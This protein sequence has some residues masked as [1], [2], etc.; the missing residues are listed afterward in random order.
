VLSIPF[1]GFIKSIIIDSGVEI[2]RKDGIRDYPYGAKAWIRRLVNL[3]RRVRALAPNAEVFVTCGDYPDD[4]RPRS[5]WIND[6]ITNIERTAENV[7]FCVSEFRDVNWLIPIQGWYRN[8]AGLLLSIEY[9]H[10]MGILDRFKYYAIANLCVE[11]DSDLIH[12]SV[13]AVRK[14][15]KD[16]GVLDDVKLHVFGLKIQS[17]KKVK[18]L[19][20]SFD[21][22]A[23]TRPVN[24]EARRI[25]N[26]SAK[27]LAERI[28]FFCEYIETLSSRYGVEVDP[29]TAEHC[30]LLLEP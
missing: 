10:K 12:R 28:L 20:H 21:S 13:L 29:R 3:Y 9:Y 6:K 19:I 8:P 18:G 15:L 4:Y 14:A 27:T 25:R 2:F 23:W 16:L 7:R 26:A 11:P 17:L 1:I 24:S 30:Q 5:L 22:T